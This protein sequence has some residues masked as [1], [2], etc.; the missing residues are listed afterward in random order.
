MK[1]MLMEMKFYQE[2]SIKILPLTEGEQE[3]Q[4]VSLNLVVSLP[5]GK[6]N[7]KPLTPALGTS[8]KCTLKF[9]S[10]TYE[11]YTTLKQTETTTFLIILI[12]EY[13]SCPP[14]LGVRNPRGL[15]EA[16]VAGLLADMNARLD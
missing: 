9:L 10:T 16:A 2:L 5:E 4:Y 6:T 15:D 14:T 12:L 8:V 13:P 3:K 7:D 1:N 11:S